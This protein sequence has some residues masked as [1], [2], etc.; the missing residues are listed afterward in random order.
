[1]Y[2]SS[3]FLKNINNA[4]PPLS[5][6]ALEGGHKG[7]LKSNKICTWFKERTKKNNMTTVDHSPR[8]NRTFWRFQYGVKLRWS[9]DT[10]VEFGHVVREI[11][12]HEL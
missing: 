2:Q 1:M 5:Y 7:K 11:G 9:R 8:Q 3:F 12:T 10:H 6:D 4:Y